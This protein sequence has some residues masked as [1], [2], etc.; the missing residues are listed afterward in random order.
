MRRW[1]CPGSIPIL[2]ETLLRDFL[3]AK[4][5]NKKIDVVVAVMAP[6]LDFLLS[7]GD[8]VFPGAQI[9]FC[10]LDR[11][12][13]GDRS[14][15]PHVRGV[16]VKREFAPTLELALRL[17][18]TTERVVVVA[19]KSDFDTQLLAAARQEFRPFEDR[20]SLTYLTDLPLQ[21]LLTELSQLPPRSIVLVTTLFQDGT[22]QPFVPHEVVERIAAAASVPVYG[23]LD[24]YLG[25]GIV[26]GSL[27]SFTA[28][29]TE[30][31]KL[32]LQVLG[33]SA[34]SQFA[35]EIPSNRVM[36]DGRQMQRW[37]ISD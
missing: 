17:H 1:T 33:G 12:Q 10:G 27:Y 14:L 21:K 4:Y 20:I 15:P 18:P 2:Y 35:L 23:F 37:S 36:F 25:R 6:A 13:L 30:A 34:P 28:H 29:G 32:A 8:A 3:R 5:A 7:F 24:Q 11:T 19:G 9:V 22:G 26:G 16:L 31:A